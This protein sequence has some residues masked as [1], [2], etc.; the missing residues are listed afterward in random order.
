M[1]AC[2]GVGASLDETQL[3]QWEKEHI[4]LLDNIAPNEFNIIHYV[5]IAEY[6]KK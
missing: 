3:K 5:A 6:K 1:K 2:R 4:D